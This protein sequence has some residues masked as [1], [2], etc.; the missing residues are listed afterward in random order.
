MIEQLLEILKEGQ[1]VTLRELALRL[2][3]NEDEVLACIEFLMQ[4][5]H[6]KRVQMNSGCSGCLGCHGGCQPEWLP[7]CP[8]MWECVK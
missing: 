2:G 6:L 5:G 3:T 8:V 1:A 7:E 4:T